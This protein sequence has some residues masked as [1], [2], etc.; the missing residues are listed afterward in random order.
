MLSERVTALFTLLGCSNTDIARYAACSSGNISKLKT[1]NREPKSTSRSVAALANGVYGYADYENLLPALQELCGARDITRDSVVPALIAWLYETDEIVLPAHTSMPK[2]KRLQ[3]L[4]RRSFGDKLDRAVNL[5]DLSN[6]QLSG[7]LNIDVSLISRYRSGIYSPHGNSYLAEKLS[8]TLVSRAEKTGKTAELAALCGLDEKQ[9]NTDTVLSWLFDFSLQ[10]DSAA[11]SQALLHSLDDFSLDSGWNGVVPKAP[12]MTDMNIYYGTEGLRSAVVRFLTEAS[13]EGGELL[14][15]SDEPMDWM[16]GD[17]AFFS[18]WASLMAKCVT[19]GVRIKIIHN[20]DRVDEEMISAVR[21]WLP[22]YISGR[23]VPF[24]FQNVRNP[25]FYHTVFLR[26]EGACIHGFSPAQEDGSR[27]Y[28]YIT[29]SK[30]LALLKQEYDAMLSSAEPFLKVYNGAERAD[31]EAYRSYSTDQQGTRTFLLSEL[32]L[33]TMPEELFTRILDRVQMTEPIKGRVLGLYKGMHSRFRD[34][35]RQDAVN[36][37]LCSAGSGDE[38]SRQLNFAPDL[39]N[40]TIDYTKDEYAM[41]ISSVMDLVKDEKNFHLTL[42]PEPP[43]RE[44][45]IVMSE[46]QVSVI[47]LKEPRTAFVF[48][49]ATLTKSVSDYLSL[50]IEG[51]AA[52]RHTTMEAL[53]RLRR[54]QN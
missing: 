39:L 51:Y 7:I 28:E 30:R 1:G 32:P 45:Q 49:N 23:I 36:L 35:L 29:D 4:R 20:I 27:W 25:R 52:D 11:I 47:R 46:E 8:D 9:L 2:S 22:L 31:R 14:L 10:E 42:L 13:R 6:S 54:R 44:V 34:L 50:L 24:I 19:K 43:F 37:I 53:D 16:T 15:Y 38:Q 5:L 12:G 41:H 26:Y 3:T 33:F 21:G 40:L 48:F 18:L 17:Q